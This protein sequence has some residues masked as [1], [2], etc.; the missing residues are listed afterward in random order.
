MEKNLRPS[1]L[2]FLA[3]LLLLLCKPSTLC[4]LVTRAVRDTIKGETCRF[5]PRQCQ[6]ESKF[7]SPKKA[8]MILITRTVD[9]LVAFPVDGETRA[10][11]T[12]MATKTS[13]A[14]V[15]RRR[16]AVAPR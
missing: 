9:D 16:P 1:I 11:P 15:Q 13:V 3:S 4:S 6:P 14:A 12:T 2:V 8:L 5:R 7:R 10:S